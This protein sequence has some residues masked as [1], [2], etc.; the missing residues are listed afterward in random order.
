MGDGD[1]DFLR[2]AIGRIGLEVSHYAHWTKS[3]VDAERVTKLF[4][5]CEL[6]YEQRAEQVLTDLFASLA[7]HDP[8]DEEKPRLTAAQVVLEYAARLTGMP[9]PFAEEVAEKKAAAEKFHDAVVRNI[10][11]MNRAYPFFKDDRRLNR[12]WRQFGSPQGRQGAGVN[13]VRISYE[14]AGVVFED[15]GPVALLQD[16]NR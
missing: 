10:E 6:L 7:P 13:S 12:V 3:E 16:P 11:E 8:G 4:H 15:Q 5:T 9:S 1:A 14:Q 2:R